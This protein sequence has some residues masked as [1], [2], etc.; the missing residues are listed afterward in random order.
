MLTASVLTAAVCKK[1]ILNYIECIGYPVRFLN[2]K[3]SEVHTLIAL[4]S[5][6]NAITLPYDFKLG[7]TPR[8]TNV[9]ALKINRL[10][11]KTYGIVISGFKL[12]D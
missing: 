1:E 8:K 12:Q 5:E 4:E 7:I 3:K 9:E 10:P 6:V 11:L 2:K